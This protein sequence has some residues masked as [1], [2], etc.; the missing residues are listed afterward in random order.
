MQTESTWLFAPGLKNAQYRPPT[1][2]LEREVGAVC[3]RFYRHDV[4][5]RSEKTLAQ[6]GDRGGF[7]PKHRDDACFA[8]DVQ[9]VK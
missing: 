6:F 5:V 2:V 7:Y 3:L 8:S 9:Q 1:Q 4:R